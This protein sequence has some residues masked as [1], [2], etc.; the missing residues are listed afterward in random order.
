[1]IENSKISTVTLSKS[2]LIGLLSELAL[3]QRYALASNFNDLTKR[4]LYLNQK[5]REFK[6]FHKLINSIQIS[7]VIIK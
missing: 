5:L 4:C 1:M 7:E 6:T 3:I 2:I